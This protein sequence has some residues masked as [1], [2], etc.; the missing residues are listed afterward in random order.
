V[1]VVAVPV[2]Q[3]H[4]LLE[5][6][7]LGV[8]AS[9]ADPVRKKEEKK[10]HFKVNIKKLTISVAFLEKF[11][12]LDEERLAVDELEEVALDLALAHD[13]YL[14]RVADVLLVLEKVNAALVS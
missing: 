6:E 8:E 7:L 13:P 12:F 14:E 1:R 3:V 10:H 5:L 2:V 9:A 11:A 4:F